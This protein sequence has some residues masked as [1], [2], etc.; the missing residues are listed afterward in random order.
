MRVRGHARA[1]SAEMH[2][3]FVA[4]RRACPMDCRRPVE[5]RTS[6]TSSRTSDWVLP[7]FEVA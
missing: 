6:R 1:I 5:A 2:V 3:W 7:Q 4:L